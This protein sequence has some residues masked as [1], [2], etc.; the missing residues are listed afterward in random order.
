M[1]IISKYRN[2]LIAGF[3]ILLSLGAQAQ[4]DTIDQRIILIGDAGQLTNGRHPVVDAVRNLIKLDKKTSIF[5]L[6]DN[7]YEFGLPDDQAKTYEG[8]RAVLD[9]Q[10]SIADGT[11]AK[12]YMIPG[13]HDWRNGGADGYNAVIREQLYVDL[14]LNK[15]NVKFYPED[16][17]PG[18]IEVDLGNNVVM[19]LF[20]SQWWLHPYDKPGIESD[21]SIKT[22]DQLVAQ[23]ADIAARNSKKLIILGCHHPFKSNGVHGGLFTLKQHIFPFTDIF[24]SAFIPLP[25]LGSVYPIARS[26]F[27]TP[28][29]LHHPNYE[30]MIDRVSTAI[31]AVAP[32]V[33]FVAGHEHNLEHIKDS[34]YNYIISGGGCKDQRVSK[35][36]KSLFTSESMGFTVLEVSNNKIVTAN[37]YTVT[38]SVRNPYNATLLNFSKLPPQFLEDSTKVEADPFAKYKDSVSS[39]ANPK[40]PLV[41][42][43]KKVF[44]GE[45]YRAEWRTPVS[46]KVF[47]L[48]KERGGMTIV[49]LGGDPQSTSLRLK[50]KNGK[51][52]TLRALN[53]NLTKTLP[54]AFQGSIVKPTVQEFN[55]ASFPYAALVTPTL[56]KALNLQ[57]P[58]AELF[59]VPDDPAFTFYRQLFADKVCTL[60]E[61]EPSADGSNTISTAKLFSKMVEQNDHRP[62]QPDVLKARL[63]DFVIGDF[64]RHFDQWK[65][66]ITD[67]GKGKVYTAIPKGRDM[68]F[69]NPHGLQMKL[70]T[71]TALPFLTGFGRQL[72]DMD[73]LGFGARDFDRLFLTDLDAEEWKKSIN[74]L[75]QKITDSVIRQSVNK[76]P[77]EIFSFHGEKLIKKMMSRRD[78]LA[79]KGM[80]Y[81][82]FISTKVNVIGSNEREY[83]KVSNSANGLEVKVYDRD[84]KRNDTSFVMY[85]RVFD[86][87]VTHEIRL[88]GLGGDDLFDIDSTASSRIK[89]RIIGGKG[90]D[91]FDIRGNVENLLYDIKSDDN[92]IRNNSRTKNRFSTNYPV[93]DNTITGFQY[94]TKKYPR[95]SFGYNS[96]LGATVGAGFS[97]TTYGFRNLPFASDQQFAFIYSLQRA[98]QFYYKGEFNHIT[99]NF[100]VLLQVNSQN[101]GLHNFFG[102]GNKTTASDP[103]KSDFYRARYKTVEIE[104]MFRRRYFEKF[105]LM[106][107]PYFFQYSNNYKNNTGNILSKP[108]LVGLDSANTFSNKAYLGARAV[109]H[110]DNRNN[111][112]FPTRGVHWDNELL[113]TSGIKDGSHNFSRFTS[114]LTL[115]VS[116][117]QP[118]KI[119][120]VLK[121]GTG[122]IF[123]KQFEYFQALTLGNNSLHGFREN[124]FQGSKSTYGSIELRAKIFDINS[125]LLSGPLWITGF[126]DM[127][128][129]WLSGERTKG[130]H[131]A[132]GGG[133]Y[134]IPFN[135]FVISATAGFSETDRA[136]NFSVGTKINLKY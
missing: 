121:I 47:N 114:D 96:D 125:Y 65:W 44:M 21:C 10:L 104:A 14:V 25:V 49:S 76:L 19:I 4:T 119:V 54:L 73:W 70:F 63:L 55:S 110:L 7:V 127:G 23:I 94:D 3:F 123:S 56:L 59:Y 32:N 128:R 113:Y 133:F 20:D 71:S 108:Q 30:E 6:G 107:G 61:R 24:K 90:S 50:D 1:L 99:R 92:Y 116:Q 129:V 60:E 38:D 45:N 31:K 81:Y 89:I 48:K 34:T 62:D 112:L 11:P 29:D 82:K 22:K 98:Y 109:L 51:E 15:K 83:F 13:N 77:P 37:F 57:T 93:N 35:S 41:K 17:C 136:L 2:I 117:N 68:A 79:T 100:D 111:T 75:Q 9:T 69:F 101:P 115:Y 26:V 88:F 78:Q 46:M 86:P 103:R 16:G 18:P 66:S 72:N 53:K 64:D 42:G 106:V 80:T 91:T 33:I 134:F 36:R 87:S 85:D 132:F 118:A 27:G 95:L 126:Y 120:A 97:K 131:S 124:R 12:V 52:W 43:L 40:M 74:D 102:L 8:Y 67:T 84:N 105:H 5:F 28:Q 58:H 122:R 39:A 135:L 130:L